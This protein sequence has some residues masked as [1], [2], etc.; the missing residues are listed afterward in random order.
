MLPQH[1]PTL[2]IVYG[3]NY[4]TGEICFKSRNVVHSCGDVIFKILAVNSVFITP[5]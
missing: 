4:I 2:F 3:G 5:N 1:N